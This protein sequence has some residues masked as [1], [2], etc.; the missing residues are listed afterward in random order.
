MKKLA[1][2]FLATIAWSVLLIGPANAVT[3]GY[4][5]AW[6]SSGS[7]SSSVSAPSGTTQATGSTFIAAVALRNSA[8]DNALPTSITDTIGGVASGNTWT[9]AQTVNYAFGGG[10]AA[11]FYCINCAGGASHVVTGNWTESTANV[12]SASITLVEFKAFGAGIFDTAPAG[13]SGG[14]S[15]F[16]T[17]SP[18]SITTTVANELVV[19]YLVTY[20]SN[21]ISSIT[22]GGS[23]FTLITNQ[24]SNT[25]SFNGAIS[26]A[27][28]ASAGATQDTYTFGTASTDYYGTFALAFKPYVPVVT[29]GVLMSGTHPVASGSSIVYQ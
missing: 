14:G 28:P 27:N 26:W 16:T 12:V 10:G 18:P 21:N 3:V 23:G 7:A 9:R 29:N 20:S 5:P 24:L 4:A 11:I 22:S 8:F 13:G 1:Y 17:A 6:A 15:S 19:D 25:A 2:L